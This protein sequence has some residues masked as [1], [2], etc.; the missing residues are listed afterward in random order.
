MISRSLARESSSQGLSLGSSSMNIGTMIKSF[1]FTIFFY[2]FLSD[3]CKILS[4][5]TPDYGYRLSV[6]GY[7]ISASIIHHPS[8]IIHLPS[9]ILHLTS[10]GI[11]LLQH[12]IKRLPLLFRTVGIPLVLCT[13]AHSAHL[14]HFE[15]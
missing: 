6:N 7:R 3:F 15:F 4:E 11:V 2:N 9:Y 14:N 1:F 5:A 10:Y 8:S 13:R 12:D